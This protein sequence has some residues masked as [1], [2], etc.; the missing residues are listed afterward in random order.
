MSQVTWPSKIWGLMDSD[1][2]RT[3]FNGMNVSFRVRESDPG[4][5]LLVVLQH[6][7]MDTHS[8]H[9]FEIDESR[10]E[11]SIHE[12]LKFVEKLAEGIQHLQ[13]D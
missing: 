7:N 4:H 3:L 2:Q 5:K 11:E 10:Y 12:S 8:E 9:V 6:P 13:Y 1:D